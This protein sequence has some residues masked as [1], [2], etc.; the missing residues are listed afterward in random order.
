MLLRNSS[1]TYCSEEGNWNDEGSK[2]STGVLQVI[3]WDPILLWYLPNLCC[4]KDI[5]IMVRGV[6][7]NSISSIGCGSGLL[8]WIITS[9]TDADADADADTDTDADADAEAIPSI[10]ADH[11]LLFCYFNDIV[12]FRLKTGE[13]DFKMIKPDILK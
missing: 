6:G 10:P 2:D 1:V 11:A 9:L 13:R 8:E 4:I 12:A 5:E 7:L 3:D